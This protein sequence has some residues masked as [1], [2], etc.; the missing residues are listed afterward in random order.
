MKKTVIPMRV[1]LEHAKSS[2]AF[3]ES[4]K[5]LRK[6]AALVKKMLLATKKFDLDD[7]KSRLVSATLF[8]FFYRA[9]SLFPDKEIYAKFKKLGVDKGHLLWF[10]KLAELSALFDEAETGDIFIYRDKAFE[11][12]SIYVS[13]Q[14]FQETCIWADLYTS[15]N[16]GK[17]KPQFIEVLETADRRRRNV[18]T[19]QNRTKDPYKEFLLE[20]VTHLNIIEKKRGF[21][22]GTV[23]KLFKGQ[24]EKQF[25]TIFI[26][27]CFFYRNSNKRDVYFMS[28]IYDLCRFFI[29]NPTMPA[30][31]ADVDRAGIYVGKTEQGWKAH[32]LQKII[33]GQRTRSGKPDMKSVF[34][35][36]NTDFRKFL[37][38]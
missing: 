6:Q 5:E 30:T 18:K 1:Y 9:L 36:A 8:L 31:Q 37:V 21:E 22:E 20:F 7:E 4:I 10:L 16:K 2:I 38:R 32:V 29:K 26:K 3:E 25:L 14:M 27:D 35:K 23:L 28:S 17:M 12:I 24:Q 34:R 19:R 33:Y 11:M 15:N 13:L